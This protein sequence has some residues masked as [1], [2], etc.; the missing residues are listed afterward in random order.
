MASMKNEEHFKQMGDWKEAAEYLS[1]NPRRPSFT[2]GYSLETLQIHVMDH[3]RRHI[4]VNRRSLEAHFGGFVVDQKRLGSDYDARRKALSTTYGQGIKTVHVAG[5]VGRSYALGP[6]VDPQDVDGRVPAVVV[7][8][9]ADLF[10]L[11]ASDRLDREQLCQIA[12]SM[13]ENSSTV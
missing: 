6:E 10:Y 7:W 2:A 3:R 1:F 5:N 4:P 12:L 13:Y 11:V 9:D 8:H